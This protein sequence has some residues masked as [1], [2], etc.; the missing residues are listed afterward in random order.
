MNLRKNW[1]LV[2]GGGFVVLMILLAMFG[3]VKSFFEGDS[4]KSRDPNH[5]QLAAGDSASAF[6]LCET[7]IK[8][9]SLNSE[10]VDL[11]WSKPIDNGE[12]WRILWIQSKR[13]KL[14]NAYGAMIDTNIICNVR[15]L[16]GTVDELII[17]GEKIVGGL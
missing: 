4:E 11:P 9:M 1:I 5:V 7:A 12:S 17:D 8:Q 14:Q 10:K 6:A 16:D 3:V 2:F 15:K 13:A